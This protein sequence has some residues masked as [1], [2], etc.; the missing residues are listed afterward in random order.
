MLHATSQC[1]QL[2][3]K[4][5]NQHCR[6]YYLTSRLVHFVMLAFDKKAGVKLSTRV[7][8]LKGALVYLVLLF[9]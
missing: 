2:H 4:H 8:K 5:S 1:K 7:E 3:T 9:S 6:H